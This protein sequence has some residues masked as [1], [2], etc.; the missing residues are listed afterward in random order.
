MKTDM[1]IQKDRIEELNWE[2]FLNAY[3]NWRNS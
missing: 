3:R 1:E 2:P